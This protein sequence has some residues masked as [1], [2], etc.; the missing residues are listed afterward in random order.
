MFS[1]KL[2]SFIDAVEEM[3]FISRLI[4]VIGSLFTVVGSLTFIIAVA[5]VK[6]P[7]ILILPI[8]AASAIAIYTFITKGQS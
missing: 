1:R 3:P 6:C 4:C 7:E 5:L 8:F 2:I